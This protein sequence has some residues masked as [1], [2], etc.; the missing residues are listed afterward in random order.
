MASDPWS[1]LIKRLHHIYLSEP[2][3]DS[4]SLVDFAKTLNVGMSTARKQLREWEASGECTIVLVK[5]PGECTPKKY[6]IPTS[7]LPKAERI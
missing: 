1:K 2:P 3:K 7:S 6:I 4:K 5:R